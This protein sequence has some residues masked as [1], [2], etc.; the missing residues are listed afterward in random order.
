MIHDGGGEI[1]TDGFVLGL[2]QRQLAVAHIIAT[3]VQDA[4]DPVK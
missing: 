2:E 3:R 4:G 1:E